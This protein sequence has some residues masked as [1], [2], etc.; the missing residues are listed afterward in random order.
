[1]NKAREKA[2]D[3]VRKHLESQYGRKKT[4][5]NLGKY[6]IKKMVAEQAVLKRELVEIARLLSQLKSPENER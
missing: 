3:N 4:K 2:V 6:N 1:M 5:V